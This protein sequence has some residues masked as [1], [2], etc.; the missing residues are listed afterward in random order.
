[1]GT[2]TVMRTLGRWVSR[3]LLGPVHV[4]G[5]ALDQGGADLDVILVPRRLGPADCWLFWSRLK[6]A[7]IFVDRARFSDCWGYPRLCGRAAQARTPEGAMKD[8]LAYWLR[9]GRTLVISID[10]ES[11]S[12]IETLQQQLSALRQQEGRLTVQLLT[13]NYDF[14][15]TLGSPIHWIWRP[16][17]LDLSKNHLNIL[18]E[19]QALQKLAWSVKGHQTLPNLPLVSQ[20]GRVPSSLLL[21]WHEVQSMRRWQWP[22]LTAWLWAPLALVAGL[23]NLAPLAMAIVLGHRGGRW[24]IEQQVLW[25]GPV[26]LVNHLVILL[27]M[28]AVVGPWGLA[29]LGLVF[30]GLQPL[31]RLA[32]HLIQLDDNEDH[33]SVRERMANYFD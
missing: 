14:R 29:Y 33:R 28:L 15:H 3:A 27:A 26:Y 1:M 25:L 12:A 2:H 6:R 5:Q 13:F 23:I 17:P 32:D 30:V 22:G 9:Q 19:L 18:V 4:H 24:R 11:R 7:P 20:S 8:R 21:S 16:Q 31:G 10:V